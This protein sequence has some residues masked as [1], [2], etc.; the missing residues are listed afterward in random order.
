VSSRQ[1]LGWGLIGTGVAAM[2]AALAVLFVPGLGHARWLWLIGLL[3]TGETLCV[4]GVAL[5]GPEMLARLKALVAPP[6]EA[7]KDD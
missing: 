2:I 4:V 6:K 7:K 1:L 3:L 5:L